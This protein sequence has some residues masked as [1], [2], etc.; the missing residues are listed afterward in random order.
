MTAARQK[1]ARVLLAARR[2]DGIQESV[3]IKWFERFLNAT[4]DEKPLPATALGFYLAILQQLIPVD[5]L[6]SRLVDEPY[7][8][9]VIS[10]TTMRTLIDHGLVSRLLE[11][12]DQRRRLLLLQ[13]STESDNSSFAATS[14]TGPPSK[15]KIKSMEVLHVDDVLDAIMNVWV[16]Y[17]QR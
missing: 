9:C 12:K 6:I 8:A 15:A 13:T 14:G 1:L 3:R 7:H 17:Q 11:T 16:R 2:S 4:H 10:H 5:R